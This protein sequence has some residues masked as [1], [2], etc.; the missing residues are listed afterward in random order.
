MFDSGCSKLYQGGSLEG[1]LDNWLLSNWYG[2]S[3]QGQCGPTLESAATAAHTGTGIRTSS[4]AG[5][6]SGA[7]AGH[8]AL[9]ST[10]NEAGTGHEAVVGTG[11]DAGGGTGSFAAS[12]TDAHL[13]GGGL[14]M[15]HGGD[16]R[17][18]DSGGR[19]SSSWGRGHEP[20][21]AGGLVPTSTSSPQSL[22]QSPAQPAHTHTDAAAAPRRAPPRALRV[23]QDRAAAASLQG[24]ALSRSHGHK[25]RAPSPVDDAV[26]LTSLPSLQDWLR[27]WSAAPASQASTAGAGGAGAGIASGAGPSSSSSGS[28]VGTGEISWHAPE[29]SSSAAASL[30][31]VVNQTA[32]WGLPAAI[33]GASTGLLRYLEQAAAG[34]AGT[35]YLE[36]GARDV[37]FK[38]RDAER[39]SCLG[40]P[41][42]RRWG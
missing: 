5:L 22:P 29:G 1:T 15:T 35:R 7:G 16:G 26:H 3:T 24:A 42:D 12:S 25:Q 23:A 17:S 41:H 28:S 30:T 11:N 36:H 14:P 6:Q 27:G 38:V 31:L 34:G 13:H 10:G 20:L 33:S 37:A 9:G 8:E 39:P 32:V 4:N 19:G 2:D 21:L 40:T 18:G